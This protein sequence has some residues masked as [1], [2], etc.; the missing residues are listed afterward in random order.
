MRRNI[1]AAAVVAGLLIAGPSAASHAAVILDQANL[2]PFVG[3]AGG[4]TSIAL[5]SNF[6]GEA[7]QTFTVGVTGV[8]HRIDVVIGLQTISGPVIEPLIMSIQGV[9]GGVPNFVTL[10]SDSLPGASLVAGS[11]SALN[12]NSFDFSG[13]GFVVT[14]GQQLS[15]VL[16]SAAD[17]GANP[18]S[19]AG[20]SATPYLGGDSFKRN[21]FNTA[22]NQDSMGSAVGGIDMLFR[23]YVEVADA[24][25][26]EPG[27]LA[28]LLAGLPFALRL[29]RR[30]AA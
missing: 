4:S 12:F 7:S 27:T 23:T 6:F 22:W 2:G 29:R 18:I 21:T 9:A 11:S 20:A 30:R 13:D 19:L 15:F 16:T 25:A 10:A 14:A 26:P 17:I 24:T 8:L 5:Q 1:R 28:L 3:S